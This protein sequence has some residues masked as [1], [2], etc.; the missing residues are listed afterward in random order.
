MLTSSTCKLTPGSVNIAA[1]HPDIAVLAAHRATRCH[2]V[3][4]S[5]R[6]RA[7]FAAHNAKRQVA[8]SRQPA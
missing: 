7:A 6:D 3:A 2:S 5:C 8:R 1:I 4:I